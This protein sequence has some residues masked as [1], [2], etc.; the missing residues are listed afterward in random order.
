MTISA[1]T[2]EHRARYT[3]SA[4]CGLILF[5]MAAWD[6]GWLQREPSYKNDSWYLMNEHSGFGVTSE[7][8]DKSACLRDQKT[9]SACRSGKSLIADHAKNAT[10][11]KRS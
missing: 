9:P 1:V 11:I 3:M 8:Q 2:V 6:A 10:S 7:Y 5:G 4:V